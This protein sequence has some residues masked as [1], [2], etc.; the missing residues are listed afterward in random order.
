LDKQDIFALCRD[1]PAT[2]A[3]GACGI[4]LSMRGDK[5]WA[6][7]PLH[8]DTDPSL[9]FDGEGRWHCFGCG[10]GGDA[11]DLYA[12]V[13]QV[14]PLEA[15]RALLARVKPA[16]AA[17]M[18]FMAGHEEEAALRAGAA[19]SGAMPETGAP[20]AANA[21]PDTAASAGHGTAPPGMT[22]ANAN[23]TSP[24]PYTTAAYAAA[25]G[26]SMDLLARWGVRDGD[27]CVLIPYFDAGRQVAAVRLRLS[28]Q[29]GRRFAWQ[30]G[31]RLIPYGLWLKG[32][33]GEGPIILCEGE[34]DAHALWHMGIPALGIPGAAAFRQE[35][36][37]HVQGRDVI[38]HVEP[39]DGGQAFLRRTVTMLRAGG[40]TGDIRQ[41]SASTVMDAIKD[42]SDLLAR[43][44]VESAAELMK[45]LLQG[46]APAPEAGR[47]A[48]Y[49]ARDLMRQH[50]P[51]PQEIVQGMLLP[52]LSLLAGAPKKGK[53]WLALALALAVAKGE[54]FLGHDTLPGG[55][56]Y[57]DLESR[58]YRV[59]ERLAALCPVD[60]VPDNLY[61]SHEAPAMDGDLCG[62]LSRWLK[63]H[64]GIRMI[65]VDTLAR[66]KGG[67]SRGGE[68][69]YEA[70]TRVMGE[71]QRF[72]LDHGLCL[73]F[74]HH[75][76]KQ[77][78]FQAQD[79]YELVSGST[80]IT[81]V[82]DSVLVLTGSRTEQ[83]A[84]LHISGRDVPTRQLALGFD[85]G[86]WTLLSDDGK[87]YT[88]EQA[89][90]NSPL[91]G[92]LRALLSEDPFWQGTPAA[93]SKALYAASDGAAQVSARDI[94]RRIAALQPLLGEREG[95]TLG[96]TALRGARILRVYRQEEREK[97]REQQQAN[98]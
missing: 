95:I 49:R 65:I 56:L 90:D 8:R 96:R 62:Q 74:V 84:Q 81:G 68:N 48:A 58:R 43:F 29:D 19:A 39:G 11:V 91:P 77:S 41:F 24:A 9:M 87:A 82:C 75:L 53:S 94:A 83:E 22:A 64:P 67:G 21:M 89:Y 50:I 3:A 98:A 63:A 92:A 32:N 57:L 52:G 5:Y 60:A 30:K 76:R 12:K 31:A 54:P 1:I 10:Q 18:A 7:C 33:R 17:Q 93:L 36:A 15:A 2:A 4:R 40:F 16:A 78:G 14:P 51:P 37:A 55:V 42:P 44:G 88:A 61:F 26:F 72:A 86:Q 69:V 25:K 79:V 6:L 46:A 59:R 70:D 34:S 20:P 13:K 97:Q 35:W 73:L 28:G 23:S 47:L 71:A 80:G 45:D 27:G 38:L 66:V 85:A